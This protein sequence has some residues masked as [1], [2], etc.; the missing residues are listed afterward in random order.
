MRRWRRNRS[1]R[2]PCA[3]WI[4]HPPIT[5][6]RRVSLRASGPSSLEVLPDTV[7][8]QKVGVVS[9]TAHAAYLQAFFPRAALVP[10]GSVA[11][12]RAALQD[13]AVDLAFGDGI[14]WSQ[15]LNGPVGSACCA[16]VGGPFTET[17]FLRR[18]GRDRGQERSRRPPPR[19][20]LC[21]M[22]AREGW[23]LCRPV[24]QVFSMSGAVSEAPH[25][26]YLDK[27][28]AASTGLS[29][30]GLKD[31]TKAPFLSMR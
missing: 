9:G 5:G 19:H 4:S 1:Q 7:A 27:V 21:A 28:A 15:W 8:G 25:Q 30:S 24:A 12:V 26:R 13:G 10:Y 29:R 2:P 11:D 31:S 3:R 18:R 20:R 17:L 14:A 23:D 16:F 22:A 6:R